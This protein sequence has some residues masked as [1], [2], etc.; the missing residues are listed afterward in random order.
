MVNDTIADM[1]TRIRNAN[2][3]KQNKVLVINSKASKKI[4]DILHSE[5]F[6]EQN[7]L[8]INSK[9]TMMLQI[10]LKYQGKK[11]KSYFTALKRISKPGL[12]VYTNSQEIPKVLG[13][14]GISIL[15]TSQG[16]MTG[17]QAKEKKIGGEI[18]CY[19]W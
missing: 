19:I 7:E 8:I 10:S 12:R 18:L 14:I 6:V 13:G 15:S 2:L 4:A 11:K 17:R 9:G 3:V 16:I 5:G 1:I